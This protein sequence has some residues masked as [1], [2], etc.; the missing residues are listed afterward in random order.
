MWVEKK[1]KEGDNMYIPGT[2]EKANDTPSYLYNIDFDAPYYP[3]PNNDI[4]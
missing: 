1:K 4:L 3:Y 2:Y